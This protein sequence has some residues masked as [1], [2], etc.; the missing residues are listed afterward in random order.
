MV[1]AYP[2]VSDEAHYDQMFRY[3]RRARTRGLRSAMYRRPNPN[4]LEGIYQRYVRRDST[5]RIRRRFRDSFFDDTDRRPEFY[6][7]WDQDRFRSRRR[8]I[9]SHLNLPDVIADNIARYSV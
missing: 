6:R 1:R 3:I 7:R 2:R 8:I 9:R 5:G 4:E